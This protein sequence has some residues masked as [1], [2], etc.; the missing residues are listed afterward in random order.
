MTTQIRTVLADPPWQFG[1]K[2]PGPSRGAERN[3]ATLSEDE[4]RGFLAA[5]LAR[6]DLSLAKDATLYLWRVASMQEE[7]LAVMRA[8]GFV[9]K[10]EVVWLK[11]TSTGKR[12]FGMGRTV[13]M[14]HEVCLIGKRGS[15]LVKSKSIRSTFEAKY[16]RHSGK[17]D[18]FYGIVESLSEGP[19]LE[20]FAR[21]RREGWLQDGDELPASP[22]LACEHDW[23]TDGEVDACLKCGLE[24]PSRYGRVAP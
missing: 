22:V 5:T 19:Y 13:R 11:K 4:L 15:P 1:D 12:W 23:D 14:E 10:A 6:M 24:E 17:P 3:Y 18:A 9:P 7:A 20:L 8:W 2:L 21:E 16:M